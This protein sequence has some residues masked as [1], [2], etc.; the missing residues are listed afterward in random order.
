MTVPTDGAE[1]LMPTRPGSV[2]RHACVPH[3]S[4]RGLM[5]RTKRYRPYL[6]V[7]SA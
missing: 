1:G 2:R 6:A 7:R 3:G 5:G 4:R